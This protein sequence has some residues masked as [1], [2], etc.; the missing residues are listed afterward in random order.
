MNTVLYQLAEKQSFHIRF[1]NTAGKID[2][3]NIFKAGNGTV[4]SRRERLS[5]IDI[6]T[7]DLLHQPETAADLLP[8]VAAEPVPGV[9]LA[10]CLEGEFHE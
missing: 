8:G 10:M 5:H 3:K 7:F 6:K 2:G 1:R 9:T 4:G